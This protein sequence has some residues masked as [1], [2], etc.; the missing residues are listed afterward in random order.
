MSELDTRRRS[1]C[2]QEIGDDGV[3]QI[4]VAPGE[5]FTVRTGP[6]SSCMV[7]APDP[8]NQAVYVS[9]RPLVCF[10]DPLQ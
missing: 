2:V 9:K 10:A 6:G 3:L 7:I 8:L 5:L 4:Q 1:V